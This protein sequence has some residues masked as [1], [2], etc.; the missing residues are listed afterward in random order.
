MEA[1]IQ[2]QA[3]ASSGGTAQ[4]TV[5]VLR[6]LCLL[7]ATR[8]ELELTSNLVALHRHNTH[9]PYYLLFMQLLLKMSK[10]CSKHVEAVNS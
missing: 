5:G 1:G 8:F 7:A 10:Q 9:A 2:L 6:V 3:L 4:T